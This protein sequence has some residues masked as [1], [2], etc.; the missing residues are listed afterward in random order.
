MARLKS[1]LVGSTIHIDG[2]MTLYPGF[3]TVGKLMVDS[4]HIWEALAWPHEA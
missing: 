1:Y 3:E 2:G 4:I